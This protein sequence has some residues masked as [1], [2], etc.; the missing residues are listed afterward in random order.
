M[1]HVDRIYIFLTNRSSEDPIEFNKTNETVEYIK[2]FL[3]P[4]YK[5]RKNKK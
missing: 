5:Y 4:T 2:N 3:D 1:T